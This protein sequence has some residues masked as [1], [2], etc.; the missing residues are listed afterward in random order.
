M[1][2][3]Y[4]DTNVLCSFMFYLIECFI[5]PV[6]N[7]AISVYDTDSRVMNFMHLKLTTNTNSCIA[8]FEFAKL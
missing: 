4:N 6:Y 1:H 7:H 3:I 8:E 5:E 2:V